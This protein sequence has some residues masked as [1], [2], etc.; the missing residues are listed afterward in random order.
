MQG[1]HTTAKVVGALCNYDCQYCFYLEK[2]ELIDSKRLMS[3]E[4][5]EQY[6]INYI[7][8]QQ[9]PTVEFAWHGGEPTLIGLEFFE[10]AVALQKNMQ[11]IK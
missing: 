8:S 2:D 4:I 5:L 7:S 3:N 1:I 11:A 6:I 9:T 10:L